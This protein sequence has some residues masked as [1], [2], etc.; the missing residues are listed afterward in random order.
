[1]KKLVFEI[2]D[3]VKRFHLYLESRLPRLEFEI[4]VMIGEKE[5]NLSKI[6]NYLDIL[7]ELSNYG[8]GNALF[9]KL[10]EYYKTVNE[11]G[12]R[13]YWEAYDKLKE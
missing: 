9:I 13:F 11:E 8:V 4:N 12:A 5:T 1:M 3:L 7:L 6:E 2:G 10:L